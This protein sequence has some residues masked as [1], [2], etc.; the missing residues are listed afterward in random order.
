MGEGVDVGEAEEVVDLV[1]GNNQKSG[2]VVKG[3]AGA[4]EAEGDYAY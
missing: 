4:E 3:E 2:R 1:D